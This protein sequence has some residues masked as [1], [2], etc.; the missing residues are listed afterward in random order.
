ME[1]AER[2]RKPDDA[3]LVRCVPCKNEGRV[4]C[5]KH[6]KGELPLED[7][8]LHCSLIAECAECGGAG[9]LDCSDCE[10]P[11]WVD[12]LATKRDRS[13][14]CKGASD[15]I[16]GVMSML[17]LQLNY[18]NVIAIPM[19]IGFADLLLNRGLDKWRNG[20]GL[21]GFQGIGLKYPPAPTYTP[22]ADD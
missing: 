3:P 18:L 14:A 22:Y 21:R 6:D 19:I 11:R 7:S 4:P 16:D 10:N 1:I 13:K 9:W 20:M 12:V 15:E 8:V 17:G 2:Q 5:S